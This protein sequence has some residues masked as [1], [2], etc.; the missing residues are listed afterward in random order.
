MAGW[1]ELLLLVGVVVVLTVVVVVVVVGWRMRPDQTRPDQ[2]SA[3]GRTVK[4]RGLYA[5]VDHPKKYETL[6]LS[7]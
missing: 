5:R 7:H 4:V 2:T 1:R 6:D 3:T